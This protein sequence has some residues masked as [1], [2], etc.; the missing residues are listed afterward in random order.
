MLWKECALSQG[1]PVGLGVGEEAKRGNPLSAKQCCKTPPKCLF[2]S[3]VVTQYW[4]T[5]AGSWSSLGA[6]CLLCL[7]VGGL[8]LSPY[9]VG[10]L[11]G[12]M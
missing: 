10:G 7:A 8:V 4:A 12:R 3:E 9:L 5:V 1:L 2:R 11:A 6:S